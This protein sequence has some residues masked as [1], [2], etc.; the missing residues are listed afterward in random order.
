VPSLTEM[1]IVFLPPLT[2]SYPSLALF[3]GHV[4]GEYSVNEEIF[5]SEFFQNVPN[6]DFGHV[7]LFNPALFQPH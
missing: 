5:C 3:P 6:P 7:V 2:H 1:G 4:G